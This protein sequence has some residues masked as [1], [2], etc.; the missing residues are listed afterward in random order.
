MLSQEDLWFVKLEIVQGIP[1]K[2][3]RIFQPRPEIPRF[4]AEVHVD[5]N[6]D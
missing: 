2:L 5:N 6:D 3:I 1:G 4:N